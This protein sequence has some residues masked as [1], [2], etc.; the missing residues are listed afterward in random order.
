MKMDLT[1]WRNKK[2]NRLRP[3][4]NKELFEDVTALNK[5]ATGKTHHILRQNK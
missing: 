5:F 4:Q 1:K 2:G 3:L